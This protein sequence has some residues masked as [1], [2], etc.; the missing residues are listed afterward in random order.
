MITMAISAAR[1][2]ANEKYNQKA[3]DQIMV[4]VKRGQKAA[5]TSHAQ[6]QGESLNGFLNRAIQN[7]ISIDNNDSEVHKT[8]KT[9]LD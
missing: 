2:R 4:R 3:Y 5:I 9:E 1:K 8:E 6:Q 7:Q